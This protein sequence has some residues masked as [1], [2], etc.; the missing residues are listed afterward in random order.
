MKFESATIKD[1]AKAL[2]LSTST[3]SRAL[4]G[5]FEI[6]AET[7]K[8]V[9]EY[10]EKINYRPNP[11]A[12]SLK[13]RRTRSLGVVVSEIANNFF[14]QAIN[15]I[16]SIAYNRG[17]H[18]TIS[19]SHESGE[20]EKVNI[21]HMAARGVDGLLVSLSSESV[22]LSFLKELHDKGLPMVFFDRVT[23]EIITHTVVAN[24]YL[25][26]FQ[27]TE[28]L[29]QQGYRRIAH[30]TSS[31]HLSITRERLE[32]YKDAL[33]KYHLP[34]EESL[35]R[36]CPHGGMIQDEVE[37]ALN[38]LFKGKNSPDAIFTAGD[39]LTM[40]CFGLL[41]RL[42]PQRHIGFTGFTNTQVGDLFAPSLTVVRQPAFEIGQS[43]TELLIQMI[44]SKRPVTEFQNK[45]L[46]TEL[47]IRES[48]MK[49]K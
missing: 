30:L 23:Q 7:K 11:I 34:F 1:I 22:D 48:S 8:Q 36:N 5:S 27:A 10:A 24:N 16:E 32:G 9:L 15:G 45:V 26:S 37:D 14:S 13:E 17:Y 49:M 6:S 21:Q 44:E 47:I 18:V 12:L 29:L 3:V 33:A 43:A 19:Q 40:T 20:R 46:D 4:R 42:N 31:P 25:G 41:K 35:L 28:H 38:S 39:R 2:N